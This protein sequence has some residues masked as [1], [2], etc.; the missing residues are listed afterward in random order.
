[1]Y[2]AAVGATSIVRHHCGLVSAY[3]PGAGISMGQF[4]LS[5]GGL[6]K[7]T[8]GTLGNQYA[9]PSGPPTGVVNVPDGL[10]TWVYIGVPLAHEV[11]GYVS[12]LGDRTWD[13]NGYIATALAG[14]NV[15]ANADRY[16]MDIEFGQQDSLTGFNASTRAMYRQAHINYTLAALSVGICV[17]LSFTLYGGPLRVDSYN[18]DLVPGLED[19]IAYFAGE[20]RVCRGSNQWAAWGVIPSDSAGFPQPR[21]ANQSDGV[22]ANAHTVQ[23]EMAPLLVSAYRAVGWLPR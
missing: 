23:V 17:S 21:R 18:N 6:W 19:A 1:M 13:P 14:R 22:H 10:I 8:Y 5:G 2:N 7:A 11:D 15:L 16:V 20:G 4:I 9:V 3:V 12:K